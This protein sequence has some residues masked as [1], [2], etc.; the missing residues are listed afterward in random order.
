MQT[1]ERIETKVVGPLV[2]ACLRTVGPLGPST[3]G[4]TGGSNR[5]RRLFN[6]LVPA[7]VICLMLAPAA[8]KAQEYRGTISGTVTDATGGLVWGQAL[9]CKRQAPGPRTTW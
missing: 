6:R 3:A 2:D 1:N 4:L 7:I 9:R 8:S 5:L